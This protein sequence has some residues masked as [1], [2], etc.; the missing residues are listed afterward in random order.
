MM[1]FMLLNI[2]PLHADVYCRWHIKILKKIKIQ[3][4]IAVIAF[5]MNIALKWVQTSPVLVQ[6]FLR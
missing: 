1:L 3:I 6:L 4:C 2:T 5:N